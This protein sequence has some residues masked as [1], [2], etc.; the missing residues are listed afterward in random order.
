[1]QRQV[2]ALLILILLLLGSGAILYRYLTA[3]DI[4]ENSQ[5]SSPPITVGQTITETPAPLTEEA[6]IV[7]PTA[8]V[9]TSTPRE[10][11]TTV[12][13]LAT[14]PSPTACPFNPAARWAN[15][16]YVE[17]AE[18][19]G[20]ATTTELLPDGAFQYY[21]EGVMIWRADT[22]QIYVLYNDGTYGTYPDD[23]PSNY[24]ESDLVKGGFG[25][26]WGNDGT[27]SSKLGGALVIEFGAQDFAV[28]EFAQGTLLYFNDNGDYNYLLFGDSNSWLLR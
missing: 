3:D 8:A 6:V 2:I 18:R 11:A 1:M 25:Y 28:Q 20:C 12:G 15:T 23:S 9:D 27:I 16:V 13:E 5:T 22:N 24:Y 19:L 14:L 26:L 21:Q 7:T 10:Q 17:F 4:A